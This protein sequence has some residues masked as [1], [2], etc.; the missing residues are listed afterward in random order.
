MGY[1]RFT[2]IWFKP[3]RGVERTKGLLGWAGCTIEQC[4]VIEGIGVR[5]DRDGNEL[6]SFQSH[7]D[8]WGV[9]HAPFRPAHP[10]VRAEIQEAIL[11][12]VHA[13]EGHAP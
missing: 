9:E 12:H 1:L 10:W 2:D 5:C 4:F 7:R 11:N 8:K 3:C 6:I 13:E